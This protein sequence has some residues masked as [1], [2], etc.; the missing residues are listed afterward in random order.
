MESLKRLREAANSNDLD[1]VQQLLEDGA[2]P[3]AADDKGRTALHFA[4]C[5]GNDH[6]VQLLLDHGADPNQ[7]DGLG[8]TP[9]HL[10][11]CTNHVPVITTL[12]RGGARVDALDRAG[13]TP[14]HLA[15]S[16]LNILQEGFSH[17][18]EAV[19]LEV[20]QIIQML[21][22]YLDRLGRHEQKEQLDDLCSR[23]QMTS[24]KEQV[25]EVTDLL[26]SFTSLSLQ[27]QKMDNSLLEDTAGS[28]SLMAV[29][30]LSLCVLILHYDVLDGKDAET[31]SLGV[32]IHSAASA[33]ALSSLVAEET[34]KVFEQQHS[35]DIANQPLQEEA[36]E[37]L[38][39]TLTEMLG[40]EGI[41]NGVEAGVGVGKAVGSQAESISGPVEGKVAKPEAEDDQVV[42]Q[43]AEAEQDGHCDNHLGDLTLG[44]PRH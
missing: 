30:E 40:D 29:L 27:M 39:K 11:A 22:E 12:L 23:L 18:L 3:C 7:R 1:T 44:F 33:S 42:G 15:K 41:D 43:P 16:K 21:R 5:N 13:R 19:R 36:G 24:T 20:K 8:N 6:I 34:I 9:L 25:D 10:A 37:G 32:H 2:D 26:A 38:L 35:T 4:S 14:L 17:S 28:S 31:P